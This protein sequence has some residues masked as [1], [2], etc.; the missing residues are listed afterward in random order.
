[1]HNLAVAFIL[2]YHGCDATI[3]ENLLRNDAFTPSENSYDW[4]GSGIYFGESNPAAIR[5]QAKG[6]PYTPA[7]VGAA[8]DLG[9]CLDLI[10]ANGITAVEE[11]YNGYVATMTQLGK[12]VS[13]NEGGE[14]RLRR[15][16]DCDVLNYL[17]AI[18]KASKDMPPFDTVRGVFV[19][20]DGIYPGAGFRRKTH[21]QICVRTQSMIKGVF[22]VPESHF[23]RPSS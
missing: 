10:S 7:V 22:R 16:L 13:K 1:V 4:L 17:H 20:G 12:P 6:T 21:V 11:A 14:D 18:R 8:I 9:F 5:S 23:S 2:G 19:E 15:N 3:A